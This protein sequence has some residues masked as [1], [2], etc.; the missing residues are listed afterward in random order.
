MLDRVTV[1]FAVDLFNVVRILRRMKT[2]TDCPHCPNIPIGDDGP[3]T[4]VRISVQV[5]CNSGRGLT[6]KQIEKLCVRMERIAKGRTDR[7][8]SAIC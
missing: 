7:D 1:F 3:F 8:V 5:T 6:P 4:S 2:K